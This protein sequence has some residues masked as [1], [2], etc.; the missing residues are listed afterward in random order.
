[1]LAGARHCWTGDQSRPIRCDRNRNGSRRWRAPDSRRGWSPSGF[2]R[3]TF[4][5][6]ALLPSL[7]VPNHRAHDAGGFTVCAWARACRI[8]V[9]HFAGDA[10]GGK[11]YVENPES[12]F[13]LTMLG[14]AP[15]QRGTSGGRRRSRSRACGVQPTGRRPCRGLRQRQGARPGHAGTYSCDSTRLPPCLDHGL[16]SRRICGPSLAPPA[17]GVLK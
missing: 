9:R 3:H 1:M 14:R 4:L 16:R 7:S 17:P 6:D 8:I 12:K 13:T 15:Y 5:C 11:D 10:I 2:A